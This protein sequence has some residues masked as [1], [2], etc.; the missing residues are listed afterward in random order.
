MPGGAG[1]LPST[2]SFSQSKK[3]LPKYQGWVKLVLDLVAGRL[4][5]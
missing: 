4:V 3:T 5:V 1:F 2:M